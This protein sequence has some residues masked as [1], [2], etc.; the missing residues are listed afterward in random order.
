MPEPRAVSIVPHTHWDREW[1]LPFQAFRMRLAEVLDAFLPALEADPSYAHFLLDGQMAVVD[2]YLEV[3]PEAEGALRRLALSGRLAMGPWYTLPDEFCVSGETLVRDLQM[4][5]ERA[6]AFGGAMQVG[7]LPDMFGHIA[8]MPQL[9]RLAGI[10]H[11][12]VWRGVPAAIDR[13][14]FWWEAPD[15]SRVRAEYLLAGYSN[16]ENVADD[17]TALVGR[18]RQFAAEFGEALCGPI[19]FM[20][21]TDHQAPQAWLG[22]VVA[23]A[24]ALQSEFDLRIRPL[25]DHLRMAPTDGLPTW[26]GELRSGA[27][28]NLLMGVASNR[29]DVKQAAARAER[30]LERLAEPLAA[31]FLPAEQW[32]D[33]LLAIAWRDLVRN[34]AHDS[35]CACSVDE[36]VDAVM[37]RYAEAR[38]IGE[39]VAERAA[40]ALALSMAREGWVVVNPCA[41]PRAGVVEVTVPGEGPLPG[42]QVLVERPAVVTDQVLDLDAATAI[43]GSIRSQQ[44]GRSYIAEID[45]RDEE[46]GVCVDVFLTRDLRA[47]LV[48]GEVLQ[49]AIRRAAASPALRLRLRMR[50]DPYRRVALR[51]PVV[52]GFGWRLLGGAE[53]PTAPVRALG[54]TGLGN[55]LV[56]VEV[57][58][59]SLRVAGTEG[60]GLL[61]E[62]GDAGDT[63]NY[64][65]PAAD[66][67]VRDP[68]AVRT[69][70]VE[71]GPVRG[72]LEWVRTYRWPAWS[73][74]AGR[75]GEREVEVT[76]VVEICAGDPLIRFTT[77]FENPCRDHRVRVWFPV[78]GG[79]V[80]TSAAECAFAVV[81]RGLTAEGGPHERPL[82]TFPS[83][84]FVRA[85][86]LT[87]VHEG[88]LEYEVVEDGRWL[89]LTLLRA[90]GMLSRVDAA[91]RPLPAGPPIPVDGAQLLRRL[92]LR[93]AVCV[94]PGADPYALADDAFCPLLVR[95]APGGGH[96]PD[97]GT[98]LTVQGA[99]V[100]A[101]R[102]RPGG[103]E[104]RVFNPWPRPAQLDVA[105]TGWVVDLRG[106]PLAPF[107]G[108][109]NLRPFEICTVLL[110][111]GAGSLPTSG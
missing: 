90:T 76:T 42:A 101:L 106:A 17:P 96:R 79:P 52:P 15:G 3:R 83:R 84:R 109:R 20:N 97:E 80:R 6:A 37:H 2:D 16:G 23:A 74:A 107:D 71:E 35:V 67:E 26:R 31:L 53:A 102:R 38:Q 44:V 68:V 65:P 10:E 11:A 103:L 105:A 5:F 14:A 86:D 41:R 60:F 91:Y 4:G 108:H 13:S 66:V 49:E 39:G 19:L 93:Y 27:R 92:T 47:N 1:Y 62:G 70:I 22:R 51:T 43:L 81:E 88:L 24:N 8:Q 72:R 57:A 59:A 99:E 89:A 45:V 54:G 87:V 7:Y 82:P 48:V 46:G 73:D 18:V 33:R 111:G 100:S 78:P 30:A 64:S 50:R 25:A 77:S 110:T 32:P 36:V 29:V 28:A 95:R 63:Y 55:G 75:H 34:A 98:A 104:L 56:D 40:D 61:V 58:G 9:L 21:G 94:D 69:R 12:V 85:G